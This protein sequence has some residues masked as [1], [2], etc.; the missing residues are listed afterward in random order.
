V[1]VLQKHEAW[2]TD[3]AAGL[4]QRNHN[5]DAQ[6]IC[7]SC[8]TIKSSVRYSKLCTSHLSAWALVSGAELI[9]PAPLHSKL[10][11]A[12]VATVPCAR[13]TNS[14]CSS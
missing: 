3:L 4:Q 13:L 9:S 2:Q 11:Q 5:A 7:R 12:A 14:A 10:G 1:T 8:R 6:A